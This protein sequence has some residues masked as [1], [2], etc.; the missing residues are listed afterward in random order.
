MEPV[1]F[2]GTGTG[3]GTDKLYFKEPEPESEPM[4]FAVGSRLFDEKSAQ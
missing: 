4:N 3:I 1:D 2:S